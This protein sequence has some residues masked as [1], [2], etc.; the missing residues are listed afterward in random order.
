MTL[1]LAGT[2]CAPSQLQVQWDYARTSPCHL[3]NIYH[4]DW[5]TAYTRSFIASSWGTTKACVVLFLL[6]G[7]L[8]MSSLRYYQTLTPEIKYWTAFLSYTGSIQSVL[9]RTWEGF[10]PSVAAHWAVHVFHMLP[11]RGLLEVVRPKTGFSRHQG[12][13]G[14]LRL[15]QGTKCSKGNLTRRPPSW[16][17]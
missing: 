16:E 3:D 17:W 11:Q 7:P 2:D 15:R 14:V 13:T 10:Y 6:P 8:G 1:G 4:R 9:S 12:P 5:Y